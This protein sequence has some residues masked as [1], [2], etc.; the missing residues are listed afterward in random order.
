[1]GLLF[2]SFGLGYF[3]YGRK[4]ANVVVKYSGVALMLYPYFVGDRV[5]VIAIGIVLLALPKFIRL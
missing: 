1:M 5:A 4:Q 2:S 3:V